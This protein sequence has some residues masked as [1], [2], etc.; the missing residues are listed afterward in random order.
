M[1]HL[2]HA[3]FGGRAKMFRNIKATVASSMPGRKYSSVLAVLSLI[4]ALLLP[5]AAAQPASA[6][7]SPWNQDSIYGC[8]EQQIVPFAVMPGIE[9]GSD[10]FRLRDGRLPEGLELDERTG[11]ISGTPRSVYRDTFVI[12]SENNRDYPDQ[13]FSALIDDRCRPTFDKIDPDHGTNLGGTEIT[14]TGTGFDERA[15]VEVDDAGTPI[16][17]KDV[18]AE[19]DRITATMPE[20]SGSGLVTLIIRNPDGS[21][22][23]AKDAFTYESGPVTPTRFL[24]PLENG[25]PSFGTLHVGIPLADDPEHPE[26]GVV[27]RTDGTPGVFEI[28][29]G[30]PLIPDLRVIANTAK[31]TGVTTYAVTGTPNASGP[32]AFTITTSVE[33]ADPGKFSYEFTGSI[34][35]TA[36]HTVTF[37]GNGSTGGTML[38]QTADMR[39][40]L[41]TNTLIRAGYTFNGWSS[42]AGGGGSIYADNALYEFAS[43]VT[44][45]AQW[46]AIPPVAHT[47]TFNGNGATAGTMANQSNTGSAHLNT[48]LY[49]RNGYEF[50][51]W[52]TSANGSGS[53]YDDGEVYS[54][55][56][57][58]TLYA[59]WKLPVP[60]GGDNGVFHTV[61]YNGN[62]ATSGST[63]PQTFKSPTAVRE[64]GFIRPGYIFHDWNSQPDHSGFELDPGDIYSF[65]A[66]ITLYAEWD[67]IPAAAVTITVEKPLEIDYAVGDSRTLLINVA[68]KEG[69]L[70][71]IEVDLPTGLLS[72][73]ALV[74]ITP[75]VTGTS[76]AAD[77]V[78]I[79]IELVDAKGNDVSKLSNI[80]V[81]RFSGKLGTDMVAKSDD[82][83]TWTTIPLLSGQTLPAN[84]VDGYYLGKDG[85]A[86]VLTRHLTEFGYKKAQ[87]SL[88][89]ITSAATS[90]QVGLSTSLKV[91]GGSGTGGVTYKVA[92]PSI[93][94]VSSAGVIKGLRVGVCEIQ[95]TRSGDESFVQASSKPLKIQ[96][97]SGVLP[98]EFKVAYIGTRQIVIGATKIQL[99][100]G[101]VNGSK[102]V[103][104]EISEKSNDLYR[105]VGQV[106]LSKSGSA[107][108]V[109]TI[110]IG[111]TIRIRYQ[112]KTLSTFKL[113]AKN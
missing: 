37:N 22:Y 80:M 57:D 6:A 11:V 32:Y 86:I 16:Y 35:Y 67:K 23:I 105:V 111:T 41:R 108:Y 89:I 94:S 43:D 47:V 76:F 27:V 103:G 113:L 24:Q 64:N 74:R 40:A 48:N 58:V 21:R 83:L 31:E 44:L 75:H 3:N 68:S 98:L 106:K 77:L 79:Q 2:S 66:D 60:T 9:P 87:E 5:F 110:A 18:R 4:A 100:L 20:F 107:T 46:V 1:A 26:L 15:T 96:V 8:V 97:T 49:S 72:T 10:R 29:S 17:L 61:T 13:R 70:V 71:P 53:N 25:S 56:Q 93:C 85:E 52:N 104:V 112:G 62:G 54:F 99:E 101:P 7:S 30:T 84:Q 19:K 69:V 88:P 38:S 39:E 109:R 12:S 42:N 36:T 63:A 73:N 55:S 50:D 90:I 33:G 81:I 102:L 82:G 91:R 92:A 45:Y 95:A 78:T 65:G 14:I 34:R 51:E 28:S 59:M